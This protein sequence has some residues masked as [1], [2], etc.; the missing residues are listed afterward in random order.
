MFDVVLFSE[1][2]KAGD[3]NDIAHSPPQMLI[4]ESIL[5]SGALSVGRM[6]LEQVAVISL[7][8]T[9]AHKQTPSHPHTTCP[10]RGSESPREASSQPDGIQRCLLLLQHLH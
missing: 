9:G 8:S 7:A 6:L 1:K 4:E 5:A 2:Y 10:D 3:S